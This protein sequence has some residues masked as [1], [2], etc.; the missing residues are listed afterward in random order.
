[1]T[2]DLKIFS[3]SSN[4]ELGQRI[5]NHLDIPMGKAALSRFPDNETF[6]KLEE[7]IRGR[8]IFLVQSVSHDPNE[9]L[10]ELLIFLDCVRR[11]SAQRITAVLPYYGYARQDR[12]DEGRTPI[13]AKLVANML[14][15]AG[16][17][18]ILT[19]DLHAAQIQGFFDVPLDHLEAR[20]VFINYFRDMAIQ[21][22]TVVSPDL[23][24]VKRARVCA[25]HLNGRLAIVDKERLG[26]TRVRTDTLIGDVKD[27]NVVIFDDI[28]STAGSVCAA[29]K[30]LKEHGAAEIYVAATHALF[31]DPGP[32]RIAESP[33]KEVI[34]SDTVP[35]TK[36][37][38]KLK[39]LTVLSVADLLGSAISRI[40]R[41][42]SV[43]SLFV[44]DD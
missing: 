17:D 4:P 27:R 43:S 10:M 16:A 3:G 30:L 7:D 42:E 21:D 6:I 31:C 33:I 44:N 18:R 13:T 29:A 40:H 37:A 34:V 15:G 24:S 38:A 22:L 9:Y 36:K 5:C 1:M 14:V 19:I 39:K 28:I 41:N 2:R 23:G 26:S 32:E 25:E 12:K 20:P 11:A 35:L 8:D